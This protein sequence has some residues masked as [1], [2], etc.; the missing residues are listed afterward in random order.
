MKPLI[1]I[2][3]SAVSTAASVSIMA[4]ITGV[5]L[6]I[7]SRKAKNHCDTETKSLSDLATPF[8]PSKESHPLLP[9]VLVPMFIAR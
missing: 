7:K 9:M 3:I 5:L 2:A 1:Q 8:A 4:I 6:F